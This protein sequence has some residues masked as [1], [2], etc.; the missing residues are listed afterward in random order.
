M[1]LGRSH[2]GGRTLTFLLGMTKREDLCWLEISQMAFPWALL[3]LLGER[4][5][6]TKNLVSLS[7]HFLNHL[8]LLHSFQKPKTKELDNKDATVY[9]SVLGRTD[10]WGIR[11]THYKS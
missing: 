6:C 1:G 10:I 2:S 4:L 11:R 9:Q 3:S 8:Y 7:D 5:I